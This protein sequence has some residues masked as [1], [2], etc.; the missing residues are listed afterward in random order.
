MTREN[1]VLRLCRQ[2][3]AGLC[4]HVEKF[5]L[6][7]GSGY[8]DGSLRRSDLT[9]CLEWGGSI[10]RRSRSSTA[11]SQHERGTVSCAKLF[12]TRTLNTVQTTDILPSM[13]KG[14]YVEKVRTLERQRSNPQR[15]KCSIV[16]CDFPFNWN[17]LECLGMCQKNLE[18]VYLY[19]YVSLRTVGIA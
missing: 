5:T 2:D 16:F 1:V 19:L 4:H 3:R 17:A 13:Q 7:A 9:R 8:V 15:M 18:Y 11:D 10:R 6:C 14:R 12:G